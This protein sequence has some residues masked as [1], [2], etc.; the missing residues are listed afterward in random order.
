MSI[1][2]QCPGC[3]R[4]FQAPD[5][6]SG[7]RV[8]CPNCSAVISLPGGDQPRTVR[9]VTL[10]RPTSSKR[11]A[12]EDAQWSVKTA[13]GGRLGPMSKTRLDA[14]VAEGRLDGFC[15]LR[16]E[17]WQQWKWAEAVF[18]EFALP[19]E[20]ETQH[21]A[22]SSEVST[23]PAAAKTEPRLRACPD[24]GKMIC[25][26]AGQCPSCGCPLDAPND[27]AAATAAQQTAGTR[28]A[29]VSQQKTAPG[30]R[31]HV[32]LLV[33]VA[34]SGVLLIGVV[35]VGA[36]WML[37]SWLGGGDEPVERPIAQ[38]P[39]LPQQPS[40]PGEVEDQPPTPEEIQQYMEEVAAA[41]AKEVDE[42]Y[43]QAHLV[44]SGL[45]KLQ[46][47][48]DLLRSVIDNPLGDPGDDLTT[49]AETHLKR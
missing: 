17:D 25:R 39:V 22:A 29:T 47:S 13:D 19:L 32:R 37:R 35:V 33:A 5:K 15:H 48:A 49:A 26:R 44:A 20:P 18:P 4:K 40:P 2:G 9:P 8:K 21:T 38:S 14:L 36:A 27:E 45:D 7:R 3:G 28:S 23:Q 16:R 42:M 6:L 11:H 34:V 24:C 30:R 46:K 41:A 12:A 1:H 43:R 10:P 31:K